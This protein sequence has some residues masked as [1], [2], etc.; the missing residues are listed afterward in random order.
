[1]Y[2]LSH[3]DLDLE[4]SS[5]VHGNEENNL[6]MSPMSPSSSQADMIFGSTKVN[7]NSSTPYTD[8]TQT[9]K[10]SPHHIKRPMNAFMVFSHM[11]RKKIIEQQP[12]IHNAEVSKALG[13]KWK[14]L[15]DE[16]REPYIQEAERLRLLHMRQYPDYKYQP[17]KRASKPKSPIS[18]ENKITKSPSPRKSPH[19]KLFSRVKSDGEFTGL[20][21]TFGGSSFV[22]SSRVK[23]SPSKKCAL[24][25][26]D[27]NRLNLRLTI[28]S[29]FKA[30]L[31][32]SQ[33]AQ[34][35]QPMSNL[36]EA[37]MEIEQQN[38]PAV[39]P[40]PSLVVQYCP[41][42]PLNPPSSPMSSTSIISSPEYASA[43]LYDESNVIRTK[44]CLD[45]E[46]PSTMANLDKLEDL[47]EL[48]QIPPSEFAFD[49]GDLFGNADQD[50]SGSILGTLAH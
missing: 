10:Q 22:N 32:Q 1:M 30:R 48:L 41:S 13:R 14:D 12:D 7:R 49:L 17:R 37:A 23:F 34:Q 36:A 27:H 20:I 45:S 31:R 40:Q 44:F 18:S 8:A 43:S 47:S 11:E 39:K 25:N 9:K 46:A 16:E 33:E 4:L 2:E 15:M 29:K 35:L 28:D 50:S 24:A 21:G 5:P 19:Q 26:V 38:Q 6:A 3:I 42:S